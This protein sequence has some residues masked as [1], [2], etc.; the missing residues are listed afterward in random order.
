MSAT[1]LDWTSALNLNRDS[2]F[3]QAADQLTVGGTPIDLSGSFLQA[4]GTARFDIFGLVSGELSFTF[5]QQTVNVDLNHDGTITTD[6]VAN[7]SIRGP[8]GPDLANAT[9]TT[10]GLVVPAGGSGLFVGVDGV[11]FTVAS[12]SLAL[13]IVTPSKADFDAG[14][15]RSWLALTAQIT[16]GSFV[17]VTGL[18]MTVDHLGVE[19]NQASGVYTFSDATTVAAQPLDWTTAIDLTPGGAF[20]ADAVS[21]TVKTPTGPVTQQIAYTTG[22]LRATGHATI[23]VFGFVSGSVGFALE[24]QTVDATV[25]GGTIHSASLLTLA[26]TVDSLFVGVP[27]GIGFQVTGGSLEL[28]LLTPAAAD[29]D[30]RSWLGLT[31]DLGSGSLVGVAGLTLTVSSLHVDLNQGQISGTGTAPAALNW[32]AALGAPVTITDAGGT[33][34]QIAF[35]GAVERASGSATV[36][37]FGLVS[38][39]VSFTFEKQTVDAAV[40]S[41]ETLH[42]ATLTTISLTVGTVFLGVNGVG[43]SITG[44]TLAVATLTPASATDHRSWTAISSSITGASLTGIPGVTIT[45]S[46]L[47][48]GINQASGGATALDWTAA[49]GSPLIVGGIPI[50]LSGPM[51]Q[52]TADATLSIGG[53][54]Y[55]SGTFVF[56]KGGNIFVTPAGSSTTVNVSLLEIG[57][58]NANVF[59]GAGASDSTGLGGVGVRLQNVNLGLA[60]MKQVGGDD[61]LLRAERV[62]RRVARRRPRADAH[63]HDPGAGQQRVRRERRRLHAAARRKAL[64]PD[65]RGRGRADRRPRVHRE[66]PA[67]DRDADAGDRPVR[68]RHRRLRVPAGRHGRGHDGERHQRQRDVAHGRHLQRV[69]VLRHRRPVLGRLERRRPDHERRHARIR[70]R[71]GPRDQQR[72]RRARAPDA[73]RHARDR[74]RR[75]ELLRAPGDRQRL[76]RRHQRLHRVDDER[77]RRDQPGA[78]DRRLDVAAAINFAA[79]GGLVVPTGPSS[80]VTLNFTGSIFSASGSLSLSI[81][82][83]VY[84]SGDV[85]FEKGATIT[86]AH[87]SDGSRG[88]RPH[89]AEDRREQRQRLRR[90]QRPVHGLGLELRSASRSPASRSA[91]RC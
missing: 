64:D 15:H 36:D 81:G 25:P 52:F 68:L 44:G 1:P 3:G 8:P 79:H 41:T 87:L 89:R 69:R 20:H 53:F 72:Q 77:D 78:R 66:P 56:Q 76:A 4:A 91:S 38:G 54:V 24:T 17:G 80:S 85:A 12:G 88:R 11:G 39:T 48:L 90:D 47:T 71:A 50:T 27:G 19:I 45:A 51:L 58:G 65:R 86:G 83:F 29:H 32:A 43:F 46:S 60:L 67:R 75:P 26:L 2:H 30:L 16:G 22:K 23:D 49:L 6:P 5:T 18:T 14:D 82:S 73:R 34:H 55:V 10:I 7:P 62:R 28:A 42:G 31:A 37:L 59:V 84:V 74:G 35:T 33:D 63:R 61:E 9:L 57:V 40:S 21:V 70:R 13:A